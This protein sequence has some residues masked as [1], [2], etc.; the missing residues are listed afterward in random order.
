MDRQVMYMLLHI[1][2]RE[3]GKWPKGDR[4]P[5]VPDRVSHPQKVIVLTFRRHLALIKKRIQNRYAR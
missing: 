5:G 3:S 4:R 2:R 1:A